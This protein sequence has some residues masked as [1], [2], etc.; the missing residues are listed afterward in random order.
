MSNI[1]VTLEF[2]KMLQKLISDKL[3]IQVTQTEAWEF[4]KQLNESIID[5]TV[6]NNGKVP[7]AGQVTYEIITSKPSQVKQREGYTA[8]HKFRVR[9]STTLSR[10]LNK[11]LNQPA[12]PPVE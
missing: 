3:G 11:K 1:S 9:Q 7:L 12:N 4:Y 8:V 2:K 10:Y 6:D 5:F